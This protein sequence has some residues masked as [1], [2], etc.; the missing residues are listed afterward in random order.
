[1]SELEEYPCVGGVLDGQTARCRSRWLM[2]A[3]LTE[4][5][6]RVHHEWFVEYGLSWDLENLE[7]LKEFPV[8][9]PPPRMPTQRYEL[10]EG[11]LVFDGWEL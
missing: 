9:P 10:R 1:M 2:Q 8:T 11:V 4:E 6:A 7:G 3:V 5:Y